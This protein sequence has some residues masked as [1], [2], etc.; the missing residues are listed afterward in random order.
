[1]QD[2]QGIGMT[3]ELTLP[4]FIACCSG[5]LE[6]SV[7]DQQVVLGNMTIGGTVSKVENLADV[8]QVCLDAGAKRILLP[9]SSATDIGN[10]PP[11][12][13]SKFQT[14]FYQDPIDAVY[15]ALGVE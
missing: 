10:V 4:V 14:A 2:L 1:M 13:F 9:M 3:S 8:L 7:Q 11:E 12:L 15:K 6:K 5:A